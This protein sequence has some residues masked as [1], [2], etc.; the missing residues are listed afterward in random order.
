[1][2]HEINLLSADG[3]HISAP[4]AMR[5]V[6]DNGT[7]DFHGIAG[8]VLG[9]AKRV[10]EEEAGEIKKIWSGLLDDVLGAKTKHT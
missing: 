9:E 3:T 4:S 1:M 2:K 10:V 7:I 5:E 8:D 6:T